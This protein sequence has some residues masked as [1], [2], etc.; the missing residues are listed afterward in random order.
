MPTRFILA[1]MV[2]LAA[3]PAAAAPETVEIGG[4]HRLTGALFRPQGP[5]PLPVVV[6]MHGCGGL[7]DTAGQLQ[8]NFRDWADLL[9]KHGYAVLFPD[10]FGSRGLGSQCRVRSRTVQPNRE[11]LADARAARHWLLT[12]DWVQRDRVSLLGWSNGAASVLWAARPQSAPHDGQPD[13]RAVIAFYPGCKRLA[14]AAWSARI[15]TLILMGAADDWTPARACEQMVA[16]AQGR[17]AR[18]SIVTY[19]GAY[20]RFDHL[21]LPVRLHRGLAFTADNS[22]RAHSGSDPEAREDA[23]RRTLEWLGR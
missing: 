10:S 16:G 11:R 12:Q 13:F 7:R 15:P 20:H 18:A 14:D 22:G 2:A 19:R 3:V 8:P 1:A 5:G 9:G 23:I 17:S 4:E 6:A 21:G